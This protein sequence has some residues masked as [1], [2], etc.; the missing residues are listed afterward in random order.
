MS[1]KCQ[2]AW[3]TSL[4]DLTVLDAHTNYDLLSQPPLSSL[5]SVLF[6]KGLR[7]SIDILAGIPDSLI[8]HRVR[9]FQS[10]MQVPLRLTYD[11]SNILWFACQKPQ[12]GHLASDLISIRWII[13]FEF[14]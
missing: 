5:E 2:G 14:K 13:G 9:H 11:Y 3:A 1:Q 12:Y 4:S 8:S 6:S 7:N 10:A